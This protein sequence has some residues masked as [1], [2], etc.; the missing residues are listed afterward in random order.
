MR[1]LSL[2][3]KGVERIYRKALGRT[4]F[5]VLPQEFARYYLVKKLSQAP[6]QELE[7]K[8]ELLQDGKPQNSAGDMGDTEVLLGSIPFCPLYSPHLSEP[9]VSRGRS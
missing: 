6:P 7:T 8:A 5:L 1:D 4:D 2:P 9:C 3:A